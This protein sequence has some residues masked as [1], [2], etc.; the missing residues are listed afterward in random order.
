MATAKIGA[1]AADPMTGP[2]VEHDHDLD[3]PISTRPAPLIRGRD[4]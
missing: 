1:H 3:V 2:G 4:P